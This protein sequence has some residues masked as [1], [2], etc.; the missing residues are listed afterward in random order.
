MAR[1]ATISQQ[2]VDAVAEQLRV[3][4]ERPTARAVRERLGRGSMATVLRYLQVWQAGQAR[5]VDSAVALP[6]ALQRSLVDFV[7]QE[8]TAAR[9]ALEAELALAQQV[10]AD[11]LGESERQAATLEEMDKA[12]EALRYERAEALGRQAQLAADLAASQQA[13]EAQRQAAEAARTELA[14][15]RVH[16][17]RL[18]RL[19]AEIDELGGGF[20]VF[21]S[22]PRLDPAHPGAGVGDAVA[23]EEDALG[24]LGPRDLG[25]ERERV[26]E[27]NGQGGRRDHREDGAP[28]EEKRSVGPRL[29]RGDRRMHG[30]R[31]SQGGVFRKGENREARTPG[32]VRLCRAVSRGRGRSASRLHRARARSP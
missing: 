6:P 17:D 5:P 31:R 28:G 7:G 12:L 14:T 10:N 23:E 2:E 21:A 4:G 27:G 26:E 15:Q 1:D 25:G 3:G 29:G 8:V 18:P 24:L 30:L 22:E 19:E 16:L 9:A 20:R 11:L 13:A 32:V